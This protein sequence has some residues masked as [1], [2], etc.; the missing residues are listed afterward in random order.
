MIGVA[1]LATTIALAPFVTSRELPPL[2]AVLLDV[3]DRATFERQHLRGAQRLDIDELLRADADPLRVRELFERAGADQART[4]IVYGQ[5]G[6]GWG[7]EGLVFWSLLYLGHRRVAIVDGGFTAAA[8]SGYPLATGPAPPTA[9]G[10]L[11]VALA[12]ELLITTVDVEQRLHDPAT[13]F[14]DV[15]SDREWQGDIRFGE[16]RAGHILKSRHLSWTQLFRADG[17][18]DE[19]SELR[20][21]VAAA[22]IDARKHIVLYCS[23]GS[24]AAMVFAALRQ[25]GIAASVYVGSM[26]AWTREPQH[27]VDLDAAPTEPMPSQIPCQI[28]CQVQ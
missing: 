22:G 18:L 2:D 12:P 4:I 9:P 11:A 10:R 21:L 3:R 1:L 17:R 8:E 7:E 6:N 14:V 20:R 26:R 16:S 25:L 23:A 13:L 24:R 19:L 28:P 27:R 5:A 15:R